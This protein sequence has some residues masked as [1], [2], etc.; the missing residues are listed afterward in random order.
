MTTLQFTTETT[1]SQVAPIHGH[2]VQMGMQSAGDNVGLYYVN[3]HRDWTFT[4][5]RHTHDVPEGARVTGMGDR[6]PDS[7]PYVSVSLGN[8]PTEAAA[9]QM[10]LK[11]GE[12][13]DQIYS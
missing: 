3:V 11:I 5:D 8:L 10:A 4:A 2:R 1:E 13:L 12:L 9:T 6:E 7:S